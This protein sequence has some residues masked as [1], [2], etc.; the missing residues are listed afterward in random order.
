MPCAP[1]C[2]LWTVE[3]LSA[4][5]TS[6]PA[7]ALICAR[8]SAATVTSRLA[9]KP[10]LVP[11]MKAVAPADCS[12]PVAVAISGS[13]TIASTASNSTFCGL[14]PMV[15]N[16]RVKPS[17]TLPSPA[18]LPRAL[19]SMSE[20]L[21]AVTVTA[22]PVSVV[23]S[24]KAVAPLSTALVTS[25]PLPAFPPLITLTSSALMAPVDFAVTETS[26]LAVS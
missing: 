17:A 7:T 20:A 10:L 3:S 22:P 9:V 1:V 13:P 18:V 14:K 8:L 4:C 23:L 25:T 6:L 5:A 21:V 24:M 2:A 19:A 15:L 11:V 26:P 16:A 12:A